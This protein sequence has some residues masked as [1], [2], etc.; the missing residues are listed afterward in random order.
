VQSGF[1]AIK[2]RYAKG[3]LSDADKNQLNQLIDSYA[4]DLR[5]RQV[6]TGQSVQG[7]KQDLREM[8]A[9]YSSGVG[10]QKILGNALKDLEGF[11]MNVLKNQNPAYASELRK[12]D[13]AFRD[14]VRVQTA[15][16]K[17]RGSE[18][19]FTPAQLEAAVRQ[20]DKSARKGAFARGAAPMQDFSGVATSVLGTKVPDSGT[21]GRGMT[22]AALTGG[23]SMVDPRM[24][25]L[26]AI[27]S[28]PYFNLGEKLLFAPRPA[29]FSEAVQR[30]RAA[31][32]F[33]VP[34][35]L[36]LTQ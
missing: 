31:S 33:A 36:G 15:M 3:K 28:L 30:A 21:A 16:S 29:A 34:G 26:S 2:N 11:Y 25:A 20:T 9:T 19:V 35:L 22:A 27:S 7:I 17:T 5:N 4:D 1:D 6:I 12:A 13:S 23:L 10:S 8:A 24:A 14:F 32:P 18:G